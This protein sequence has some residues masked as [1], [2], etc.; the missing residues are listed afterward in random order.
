MNRNWKTLKDDEKL[1]QGTVEQDLCQDYG[2]KGYPTLKYFDAKDDVNV[3]K[4]YQGGE[5]G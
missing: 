3:A 2:V 1:I 4:D 5:G